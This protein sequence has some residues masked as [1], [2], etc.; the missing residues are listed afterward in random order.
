MISR[1]W[2]ALSARVPAIT[3]DVIVVMP[4]HIHGIVILD[5]GDD[6]SKDGHRQ[7]LHSAAS[8]DGL[9]EMS[10]ATQKMGTSPASSIQA[11]KSLTTQQYGEGV[12]QV[13]WNRFERRLFSDFL[14]L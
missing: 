11:F 4:D 6:R 5:G 12:Q 9:D 7:A 14:I 8:C 3:A 10:T 2:V 1:E 13:G